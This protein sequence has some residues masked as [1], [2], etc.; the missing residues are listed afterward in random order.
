MPS[1]QDMTLSG[2]S[3]HTWRIPV[4][5]PENG[6]RVRIISTYVEN[7]LLFSMFSPLNKDHLHIRGE[8][9]QEE[10][11]KL[12]EEGSSPHTWRIHKEAI[13]LISIARIISTYVENTFT[14][15][16]KNEKC[17]DHLHIRGEYLFSVSSNFTRLGSSPHTWR[18]LLNNDLMPASARD[19][20]HIRGEYYIV[21]LALL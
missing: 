7:T 1:V 18:I 19:H 2:S 9:L 14:L 21:E 16:D 11:E 20:L 8:Y 17:R 13:Q 6:D 3:P 10:N 12:R 15:G 4:R 5:L